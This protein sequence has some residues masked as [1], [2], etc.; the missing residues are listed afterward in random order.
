MSVFL[1]I[2]FIAVPVLIC[3]CSYLIEGKNT[4]GIMF[5][6]SVAIYFGVLKKLLTTIL[7]MNSIMLKALL[8]GGFCICTIYALKCC[9]ASSFK[10]K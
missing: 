2:A 5:L 9:A 6:T 8:L 7:V 4:I 1:G 10:T 3:I